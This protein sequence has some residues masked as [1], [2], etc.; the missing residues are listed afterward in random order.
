[1]EKY[2]STGD[3]GFV[4][5][6]PLPEIL[7]LERVKIA[8]SAS[9]DETLSFLTGMLA[10]IPSLPISAEK[11]KA[12]I[13]AREK[14][15]STGIGLG[16]AFPHVRI[17]EAREIVAAAVLMKNGIPDYESLDQQ[18]VRLA[19]M[20]IAP[21]GQHAQHLRLLST[22]SSK[23]KDPVLSEKLFSADSEEFLHSLLTGK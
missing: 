7:P 8:E 5:M 3:A 17:P 22:F 19:V 23:L 13:I 12:A 9:K 4:K 21:P 15:M 14:L 16:F 18:I 11:L 6:P 2:F 1:M 20:I 10:G